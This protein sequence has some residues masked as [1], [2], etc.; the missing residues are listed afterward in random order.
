MASNF[1]FLKDIDKE[2]FEI[3]EEAQTL[4]KNEYFNQTVI[5]VRIYA[6]KMAKK[7]LGSADS[8]QTFDNILNCL[9]DK[10]K[11]QR[12]QEFIDDLFF[13]KKQGNN[14]AH[15]EDTTAIIALEVIRRAFE[16]GINY[17]YYRKKDENID[18]LNFDD[19]LLITGKPQNEN[20]I[21]DKY[22]KAAQAQTKEELLKQ[23]EGEFLTSAKNDNEDFETKI[24]DKNSL[25][26]VKQYKNP[27][28]EEIKKKIKEARKTLKQNINKQQPKRKAT[29]VSK[30]KKSS[31]KKNSKKKNRTTKLVIFLIFLLISLLL[32]FQMIF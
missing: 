30:N 20:K 7:V 29:P 10:I 23:K 4:F 1:D 25:A 19:T 9:K 31:K 24:K 26:N 27:K 22:L 8:T 3:I 21:I 2:L 11:T 13:I 28:K 32:L 16:A 6:E 5:Q 18:K 15:G 14:C 12:E 17:A